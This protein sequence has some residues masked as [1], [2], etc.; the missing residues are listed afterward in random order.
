MEF[1][2]LFGGIICIVGVSFLA[3]AA[4]TV[5]LVMSMGGWFGQLSG[6]HLL[7]KTYPGPAAPPPQVRSTSIQMGN[8]YYRFGARI[9][10]TPQG[11]YLGFNSVYRYPPLL[12]PW[13]ELKNSR[14]TL[15]FWFPAVKMDVG[16]PALT[17]VTFKQSDYGWF[18][19]YLV[20]LGISP[21]VSTGSGSQPLPTQ[22]SKLILS[23]VSCPS[24]G[25]PT[26]SAAKFC[27][28]CGK[29]VG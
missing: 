25:K 19:P 26:R 15:L 17:G 24:C 18:E 5:V 8:V 7:A 10:P 13:A 9:A 27:D 22:S 12:I 6:W 23:D 11:L 1:I 2:A 16:S 29:P 14:S 28:N 21:V 20:S 4:L 3:L